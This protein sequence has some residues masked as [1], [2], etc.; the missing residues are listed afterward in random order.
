MHIGVKRAYRLSLLAVAAALCCL[1]AAL[2]VVYFAR[3]APLLTTDKE[4]YY[5]TEVVTVSGSGFSAN[6]LY[7]IPVIRP[8]GSI[9]K[10]DGSFVPGWDTVESDEN[11]AFT[12]YYQLDGITGTYEVR[13]YNSPWSGDLDETPI[14]TTT[15]TDC[16]IQF[17]QC[18][19]DS[20]NN[21]AA[22]SCYWSTGA[23][24]ANNSVYTEG[25]SVPQRL[26]H[27]IEST[28]THTIRLEYDFSKSSVYAYDF[29]SSVDYTMPPGPAYL[30]ECADRPPFVSSSTCASLFTQGQSPI[31]SDPFDAVAL[32]EYP[33]VRNIRLGCSPACSGSV[34]VSFPSLNGGNDPGESHVPD[35][36]PDCEGNCGTSSVKVDV[37]FTTTSRN[38]VVGLWFGGHLASA[39]DPDPYQS[40]P[41]GWGSGFGASSVSGAVIHMRYISLDGGSVGTRDNQIQIGGVLCPTS[42]PTPTPTHTPTQTPTHTFTPTA[43]PTNT[44]TRTFTPTPTDT[45]VPPT[46]TFTPT[47]T[48]TFTP[49]PTK[50]ATPTATHT[51]T[52]TPTDTPVPPTATFTPTN[53]PVPPTA[54]FTPTDTPVPPTATFTPTDTPVPP[55]ATFTPTP[56]KTFT[57]TPTHTFTPT[58]TKTFTPTPTHTSTPTPTK[59]FTATPTDTPVP[60]TATFTPTPT[61]T[62]TPTPT[63]THTPLPT[64]TLTPTPVPPTPTRTP[65]PTA[66]R[67]PT[68]ATPT[69]TPGTVTPTPPGVR[70]EKDA[71]VLEAGVQTENNLWITKSGCLSAEEGKGCLVIEKWVFNAWDTDSPND[72]DSEPEG[73]GAWEEQIKFEHKILAVTPVP[74]NEWLESGGR[75]ANCTATVLTENWILTGCVTKDDPSEPG[76]QPG[77]NGDGLIE[78][79]IIVPLSDDLIYRD[80]FR[81]TKDNGVITDI[82]DENCEVTDVLAEPIPGTLPGGLTQTCGDAHITVRMLQGDLDLDCDVDVVDDQ[83]IAFRYGSFLGLQLYDQWYD[84]E[85]KYADFDVDIKDIQFVFGRNGSTCQAPIPDDQASP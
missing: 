43:T 77:P 21:E 44:P 64:A 2:S 42:T 66:T 82:V 45:P 75:V 18:L 54:T 49:T 63:G 78:R 84:L 30:N 35:S 10:G 46:A 7:D 61:H 72:S 19:N 73:L 32:R 9:V 40:P 17:T 65:S 57:P 60:P 52:P 31:P 4:D 12:Y 39:S 69:A 22:D 67:T 48:K 53:T 14:A 5:S 41:D 74:S 27:R 33:G 3:A 79:I 36:D 56:T 37:T 47:P 16:D 85:P 8:D 24:N 20:D 55:T 15:F 28:G 83:A 1:A 11:G 70:M 68:P 80:G 29:L 23:I 58:P 25:D 62:F 13:V 51:S 26:F 50:T 76:I 71:N 34:T 6:T 38:T 81:P 59:T